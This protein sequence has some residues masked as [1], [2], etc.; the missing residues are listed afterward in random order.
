MPDSSVLIA[1]SRS[2]M[3]ALHFSHD[4]GN[5]LALLSR[6]VAVHGPPPS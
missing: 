3:R 5:K 6:Q 4:L 1:S 2:S